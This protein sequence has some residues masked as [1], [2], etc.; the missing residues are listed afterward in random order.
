MKNA[1]WSLRAAREALEKAESGR[2]TPPAPALIPI[3][4]YV[5]M[6]AAE[7]EALNELKLLKRGPGLSAAEVA[8]MSSSGI[9]A[10]GTPLD[11]A[12][13]SDISFVSMYTSPQRPRQDRPT[14]I[15]LREGLLEDYRRKKG[16]AASTALR[17]RTVAL[18]RPLNHEELLAAEPADDAIASSQVE[19]RRVAEG[20]GQLRAAQQAEDE[21]AA[22]AV[23]RS[24]LQWRDETPD[25]LAAQ[26]RV[27]VGQRV[28]VR[29]AFDTDNRHTRALESRTKAVA[30]RALAAEDAKRREHERVAKLINESHQRVAREGLEQREEARRLEGEAAEHAEFMAL[31]KRCQLAL[32]ERLQGRRLYRSEIS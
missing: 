27:V 28:A 15:S 25:Q 17:P 32:A 12:G 14:N 10:L 19:L 30:D 8:R 24:M 9:G 5:D 1:T 7:T 13:C 21:A 23:H 6:A 26:R 3:D 31:E 29:Q 22:S 18:L 11:K 4:D 16:T 2:V 20:R